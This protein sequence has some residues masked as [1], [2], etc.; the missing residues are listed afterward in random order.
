[1]SP[2][3]DLARTFQKPGSGTETYTFDAAG[4][5]IQSIPTDFPWVDALAIF[6]GLS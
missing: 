3:S 5:E 6:L 4:C 1:M 2:S